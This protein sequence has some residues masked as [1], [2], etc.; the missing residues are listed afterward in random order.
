MSIYEYD[1]EEHIRL[2][3]EDAFDGGSFY[4][5]EHGESHIVYAREKNDSRIVIAAN[6]GEDITLTIP[7]GILYKDLLN[8]KIYRNTVIIKENS[9]EIFKAISDTKEVNR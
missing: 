7:Q 2:E 5:V 9:S 3:R 1:Q 8:G 6:R 4:V